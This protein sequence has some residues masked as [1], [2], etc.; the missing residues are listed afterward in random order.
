MGTAP[1][2]PKKNT[3]NA[4]VVACVFLFFGVGTTIAWFV[5]FASLTKGSS[6]LS[7]IFFGAFAGGF[8]AWAIFA[9]V[10]HTIHGITRLFSAK[11]HKAS[12]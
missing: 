5:A 7:S 6:V 12:P 2:I 11:N 1:D 10:F 9:I 8:G 3:A 4:A